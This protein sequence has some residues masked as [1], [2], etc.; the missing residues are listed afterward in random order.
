MRIRMTAPLRERFVNIATYIVVLV[1][2]IPVL[3]PL[4]W[5]ISSS[6][7]TKDTVFLAPPQWLPS[8]MEY[9]AT[10]D[11]GVVD[12]IVDDTFAYATGTLWRVHVPLATGNYVHTTLDVPSDVLLPANTQDTDAFRLPLP[13]WQTTADVIRTG[14][15]HNNSTATVAFVS[16]MVMPHDVICGKSVLNPQWNNYIKAFQEEPFHLYL[17]N[18]LFVTCA[19]MLG[20]IIS[21]SLVGYAFARLRFR[22]K[23]ILFLLLLSTMMLPAQVSMI[24]TFVMYVK[25]GWLDSFKPLL[26]PT[27]LAQSAFFVFLFRQFFMTIPADLEDAARIDGCTPLRIY[28][29]IILPLA[30]PVV[31]VVAVFSFMTAWNDFFGPLLYLN[32]DEKQ[33]LALALNNFKTAFGYRDPQLL[34]AA[35]TIMIIPAVVIFFCAQKVFIRG[36]V[37]TGVEK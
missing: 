11:F 16:D 12:L 35:S 27:M 5:L 23:N 33:T 31:I 2:V 6:L 22:G 21:C 19:G 18:T 32:S 13:S 30:T 29:D 7:K 4:F 37:I 25:I 17:I 24:P 1:G 26:A 10:S 36:V 8:V 9:H 14:L 20:N 3:L 34:M 15:S 28:W